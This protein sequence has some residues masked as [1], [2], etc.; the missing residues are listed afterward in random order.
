VNGNGLRLLFTGKRGRRTIVVLLIVLD[1]VLLCLS[2]FC[3]YWLRSSMPSFFP[4]LINPFR[5]YLW[6]TPI[7][8]LVWISACFFFGLYR[9]IGRMSLVMEFN[10]IFKAFLLGLLV[11]M[12]LAF[13]FKDLNLG[14]SVIILMG[15]LSLFT[16][17]ISRAIIRKVETGLWTRGLLTVRALVVG[18]G[19]SGIRTV[20]K[21]QD[22]REVGYRVVGFIDKDEKKHGTIVGGFPVLGG[23][24]DIHA[25][26]DAHDIDDVFFAIP[27]ISHHR[28]LDIISS[29]QR[30]WTSFHIVTDVFDVISNETHIDMIGSFPVV[31]LKGEGAG[32]GYEAAKRAMDITL[33]L[34]AALLTLPFWLCAIVLIKADSRGPVFFSQSRVGKNGKEFSIYKFRTM[35]AETDA[36]ARSPKSSEDDRITRSGRLLRKFSLDEL[37]QIINVISGDMSIVGPR[38]EMPFIVARYKEWE[39]KRLSVRPGITGLWQIIGRK[40]LPLEENIQYDFFYIKNRSLAMDFSIILR[41]IPALLSRK[42]AY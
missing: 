5:A 24:R 10:A 17:T 19:E 20:Q 11:S 28:I 25:V 1:A 21:L 14:R 18:A 39:K 4:K 42:G 3:A 37:P 40:D 34:T 27:N 7:M 33:S 26:I 30:A 29:S 16:L 6:F 22:S 9:R 31:D 38:P 12:S 41:T 2:W 36:Y 13:L 8:V 15:G 23:E 32:L 35:H